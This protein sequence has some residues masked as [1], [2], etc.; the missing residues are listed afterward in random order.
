MA[1]TLIRILICLQISLKVVR[2]LKADIELGLVAL[3]ID[4][5]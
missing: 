1:K 4:I 2:F 3:S 5:G